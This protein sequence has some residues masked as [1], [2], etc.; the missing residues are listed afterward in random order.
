MRGSDD[1]S[2]CLVSGWDS[3]SLS[4]G[5]AGPDTRLSRLEQGKP[6]A[7]PARAVHV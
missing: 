4:Y 5:K 1:L 3:F 6:R 2:F 7:E